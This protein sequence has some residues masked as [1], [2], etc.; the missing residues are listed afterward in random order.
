M[1]ITITNALIA[2]AQGS[3]AIACTYDGKPKTFEVHC[4]GRNH[5]RAYVTAGESSRP[6]PAWAL[7]R[8]DKIDPDTLD[9][10]DIPSKAPREGYR[11]GDKM[12]PEILYEL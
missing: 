1:S 9:T 10:T 8:L 11:Q 7:L 2:A 4:V 12:I 6:L 5:V 3:R